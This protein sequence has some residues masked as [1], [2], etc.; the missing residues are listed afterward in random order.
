MLSPQETAV[1]NFSIWLVDEVVKREGGDT[2]RVK[3]V[4]CGHRYVFCIGRL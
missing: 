1:D 3:V 4:L 2:G